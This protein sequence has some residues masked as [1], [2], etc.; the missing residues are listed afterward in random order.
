MLERQVTRVLVVD[1][2]LEMAEMVADHLG[3]RGY[4]ATAM[5]SGPAAL[6][7]LR[8]ERVD[9]LV[10]DLRMPGIDG[11]DLLTASVDLDPSRVVILMTAYGTPATALEATRRGAF[12]FLAKP[13][14]LDALVRILEQARRRS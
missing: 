11:F 7:A 13:F 1:D 12:Q 3:E 14:R 9:V 4:E 5:S 8:T 6:Q 10:T 2:Q